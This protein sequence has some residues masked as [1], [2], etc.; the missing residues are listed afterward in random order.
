MCL[1]VP[2]IRGLMAGSYQRA[3][4]RSFRWSLLSPSGGTEQGVFR[5]TYVRGS[6]PIDKASLR[7]SRPK[8]TSLFL[9][10][11]LCVFVLHEPSASASASSFYWNETKA[12]KNGFYLLAKQL[13][14]QLATLHLPALGAVL[15]VFAQEHVDCMDVIIHLSMSIQ[16]QVDSLCRSTPAQNPS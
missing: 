4:G 1:D 10:L 8:T 16:G 13:V 5:R 14:E 11:S 7:A 9:Q 12:Y 3:G 15:N 6:I 2:M